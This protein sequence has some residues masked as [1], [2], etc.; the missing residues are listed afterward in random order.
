MLRRTV[1]M[2]QFSKGLT[3]DTIAAMSRKPG[4][5]NFHGADEER[6]ALYLSM[7]TGAMKTKLEKKKAVAEQFAELPLE[8]RIRKTMVAQEQ[9]SVDLVKEA[10]M[11]AEAEYVLYNRMLRAKKAS[12]SRQ[13]Y[14]WIISIAFSCFL[15]YYAFAAFFY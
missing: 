10:G 6:Q 9:F 12:A 11:D 14:T 13:F 5:T 15:L 4:S 8:E 7:Q 3:K 1:I 2:R